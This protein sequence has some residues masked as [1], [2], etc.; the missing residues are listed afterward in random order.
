ML[1]TTVIFAYNQAIELIKKKNIVKAW[2]LVKT[3]LQIYPYI[4]DFLRFAFWLAVENGD[5]DNAF[6][7]LNRLKQVMSKEDYQI[8]SLF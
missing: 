5:Y 8:I 2:E 6:R 7:I 3:H 4:F 1:A